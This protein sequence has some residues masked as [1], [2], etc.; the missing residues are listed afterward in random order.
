MEQTAPVSSSVPRAVW[1]RLAA[2]VACVVIAVAGAAYLT[3]AV[4]H[5]D[6]NGGST[7]SLAA[8]RA[9]VMGATGVFMRK[10]GTYDASM[11]QGGDLAAYGAALKPLTTASFQTAFV[12][13]AQK[14]AY[15]E[16]TQLGK[17][18]TDTVDYMG[19][20]AF[21]GDKA[22][23]IV[24]GDFSASYPRSKGA[25]ARVSAGSTPYRYVVD[26]V[27]QNGTWLVNDF[28]Q[29]EGSGGASAPSAP[30]KAKGA[31]K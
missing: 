3:Y 19:V 24:V 7:S 10:L 1:L 5:R 23:V 8:D 21:S 14:L 18:S 20:A 30:A 11:V 13:E 27:R 22:T 17:A 25:K 26:L 2:L 29:A 12:D 31:K 6:S 16:V 4:T 28:A 15:A 9:E